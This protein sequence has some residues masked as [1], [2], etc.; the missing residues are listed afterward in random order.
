MR[1]YAE[2]HRG[3]D[4]PHFMN[5]TRIPPHMRKCAKAS[6]LPTRCP[7]AWHFKTQVNLS[8]YAELWG[9]VLGLTRHTYVA[10]FKNQ[11]G[12]RPPHM[13]NYAEPHRGPTRNTGGKWGKW[14]PPATWGRLHMRSMWNRRPG[15]HMRTA[16]FNTQVD[17][18]T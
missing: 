1:N 3:P 11:H 9:G 4:P 15:G 12:Y 10:H 7:Y 5:Q 13:R 16:Q 17:T 6:W 14:S 18:S 2:P 8:T